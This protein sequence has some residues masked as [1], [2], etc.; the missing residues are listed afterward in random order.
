M[1]VAFSV[2]VNL[3]ISLEREGAELEMKFSTEQ[4]ASEEAAK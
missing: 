3:L 4:F 1:Y 2:S